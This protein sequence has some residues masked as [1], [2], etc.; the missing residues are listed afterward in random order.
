M[1]KRKSA[2]SYVKILASGVLFLVITYESKCISYSSANAKPS[3]PADCPGPG[4]P[5]LNLDREQER[6]IRLLMMEEGEMNKSMYCSSLL[7]E[8]VT[9]GSNGNYK[10]G[11]LLLRRYMDTCKPSC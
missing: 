8:A 6:N 7:Q 2:L 3:L 9:Q 11:Y 5:S 4:C 1:K 10:E